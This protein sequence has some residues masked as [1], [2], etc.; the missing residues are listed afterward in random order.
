MTSICT[1]CLDSRPL[2]WYPKLKGFNHEK[3]SY[4]FHWLESWYLLSY[5]NKTVRGKFNALDLRNITF[6]G[7]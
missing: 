4:K 1:T 2:N 6:N 5:N 7:N 3:R